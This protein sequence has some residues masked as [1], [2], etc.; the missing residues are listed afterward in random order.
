MNLS[1]QLTQ[2]GLNEKQ[3]IIYL[4]LL[5]LGAS[6]AINLAK[7]T[8]ILR[9]TVYDVL[10][11]LE[12]KGLLSQTKKGKKR[13][14]LAED[15]EN[16]ETIL[17]EKKNKLQELMPALKSLLN[18]SGTKPI[19]PII[20]YYEGAEGIKEVYRDTLKYKGELVAF[21]TENIINKLG[22]DFADEYKTRRVKSQITVRVIGPNTE[23]IKEY[24]KTDQKDLKETRLVSKEEFPFSIE[25]NIFGN[26]LAFMSFSESLGLIVES[27]EIA[28]NIKFLFE[29][30]WRGAEKEVEAKKDAEYWT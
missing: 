26:K 2:F 10:I 16:L 8:G 12:K 17:E 22:Q 9:T 7:K 5:E 15:P 14:F 27:N 4:A 18:T 1:D 21:V 24:K 6:S 23:E 19:I 13:L 25:M 11:E 30:A 20:R 28:K 29:L 3:A